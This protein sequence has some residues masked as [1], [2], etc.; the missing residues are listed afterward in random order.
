M[1]LNRYYSIYLHQ[2]AESVFSIQPGG[3]AK[4]A[5]LG[6]RIAP[7]H[8]HAESVFSIQTG[9]KLEARNPGEPNCP[10]NMHAES[11]QGN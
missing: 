3:I 5:P 10:Q 11:V 1:R 9:D 8:Q 7:L 4:R 2:H 6:S